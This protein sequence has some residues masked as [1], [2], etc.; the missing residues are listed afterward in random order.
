MGGK[1]KGKGGGGYSGDAGGGGGGSH[2]FAQTTEDAEEAAASAEEAE[3]RKQEM[4]LKKKLRELEALEKRRDAGETLEPLQ[5]KKLE[6]KAGIVEELE[7]LEKSAPPPKKKVSSAAMDDDVVDE[8]L[9][10][11]DLG[12]DMDDIQRELQMLEE[13][14]Q[15]LD[16]LNRRPARAEKGSAADKGGGGKGGKGKG[17]DSKAAPSAPSVSLRQ[18]QAQGKA[19]PQPSAGPK[20]W[21]RTSP[22]TQAAQA[23]PM[24]KAAQPAPAQHEVEQRLPLP[25]S[26][27]EQMDQFR[28]D[29]QFWSS[30]FGC[31]WVIEGQEIAAWFSDPQQ[32]DAALGE[33]RSIIQFDLAGGAP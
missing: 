1:G 14:A 26:S 28:G 24:A 22:Q 29:V 15:E 21:G 3:R 9:P 8:E 20:A 27:E 11:D 19:M 4:K 33:L 10:A 12:V 23:W 30:K 13:E 31:S 5:L 2:Y 25:T 6:T 16:E 7:K 32:V 18:Q 17:K